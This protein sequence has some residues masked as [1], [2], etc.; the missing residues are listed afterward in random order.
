MRREASCIQESRAAR[1]GHDPPTENRKD[2]CDEHRE[3]SAWKVVRVWVRAQPHQ[4]ISRK[5]Q[6]PVQR[7]LSGFCVKSHSDAGVGTAHSDVG[8]GTARQPIN[9]K[10]QRPVQ[11]APRGFCVESRSGVGAGTARQSISRKPQRIEQRA[12]S[13]FCVESRSEV[14]V[15]TAHSDAG[16]GTA[17]PTHKPKT[18][19]TRATSSE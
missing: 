14:G 9:R 11:R 18:A 3:T 16:V 6:R 8:A 17:P 5:P 7:A 12:Q 19:K 1:H 10:P 2:P 15:G 4:P 13:G